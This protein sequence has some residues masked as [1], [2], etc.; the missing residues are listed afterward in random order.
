MHNYQRQEDLRRNQS[1]QLEQ[2]RLLALELGLNPK[3][4]ALMIENE[5]ALSY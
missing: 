4:S 2:K 3:N 1:Q 5:T